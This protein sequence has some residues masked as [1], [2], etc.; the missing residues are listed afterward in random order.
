MLQYRGLRQALT[1][2]N[3]AILKINLGEPEMH[4]SQMITSHLA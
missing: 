4:M 1:I 3:A 2:P